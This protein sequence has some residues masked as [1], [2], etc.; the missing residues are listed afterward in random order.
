MA[1]VVYPGTFDPITNGHV[2]LVERNWF[3]GSLNNILSTF[4]ICK[5][6]YWNGYINR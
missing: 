5:C 2:D 3:H 4:N 1:Q 6:S